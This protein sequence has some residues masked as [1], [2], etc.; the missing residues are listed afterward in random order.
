MPAL[1]DP[2]D[3]IIESVFAD[4]N[5]MAEELTELSEAN[6]QGLIHSELTEDYNPEEDD[7]TPQMTE[8]MLEAELPTAP[9]AQPE[10]KPP[11]V[12]A[13]SPPKGALIYLQKLKKVKKPKNKSKHKLQANE[14]TLKQFLAKQKR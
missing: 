6:I 13:G 9:P 8:I 1:P 14:Q 5:Y 11:V 4:S 10:S 12:P 7:M 2:D 3:E